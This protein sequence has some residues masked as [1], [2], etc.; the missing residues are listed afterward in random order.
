MELIDICSR[1]KAKRHSLN[2][3]IEDV[4]LKTKL[5]P[6]IITDIENGKTDSINR[7]YLKGF[8]KIYASSL[9]DQDIVSLVEEFFAKPQPAIKKAQEKKTSENVN[10]EHKK[11]PILENVFN[12]FIRIVFNRKFILVVGS[13]IV[14]FIVV[15]LLGK[16]IGFFKNHKPAKKI[17]VEEKIPLVEEKPV[18]SKPLP[19]TVSEQNKVLL[20]IKVKRDCYLR[21]KTD[22][23]TIFEGVINKGVVKSWKADKEI[24]LFV[25]NPS[26][27]EM[28]IN[29]EFINN[30]RNKKPMKYLITSSGFSTER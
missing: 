4:S 30:T 21:V 10:K 22:G 17:V 28:E 1:I 29:G 14:F 3:S 8:L 18:V 5:T 13:V 24:E 6:G 7:A 27:L 2:L 26:F 12:G 11:N 20:G 9:K 16:L 25:N 15:S 19:K 23:N